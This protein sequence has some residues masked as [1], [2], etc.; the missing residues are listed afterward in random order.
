MTFQ[1]VRQHPI[2]RP[3]LSGLQCCCCVAVAV[4][5]T[6]IFNKLTEFLLCQLRARHW[7][8]GYRVSKNQLPDVKEV[9]PRGGV[10]V[11]LVVVADRHTRGGVLLFGNSPEEITLELNFAIN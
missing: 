9:T 6:E 10:A 8:Q 11:A 1:L 5:I 7:G 2:P 3:H 4:L